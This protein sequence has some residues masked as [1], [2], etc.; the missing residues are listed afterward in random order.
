MSWA[1]ELLRYKE[2][3]LRIFYPS[4]CG[5]CRKELDLDESSLCRDCSTQFQEKLYSLRERTLPGP[6]LWL[7]GAWALFPYKPPVKDILCAIKMA[8]KRWLVHLFKNEMASWAS[9]L[10]AEH[11]YEG[12][13]P[14]PIALRKLLM[15]QFNQSELLA[16]DISKESGIPLFRSLLKKR[17]HVPAQSSLNRQ[18][19]RVNLRGIFKVTDPGRVRGHA[20]LLIDDI[21]TTG[22][23]AE[24]AAQALSEAGA[25]RIDLL[26]VAYTEPES[27]FS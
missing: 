22:A 4:F 1:L 14:V 24:A 23:T 20:W 25:S 18:E 6:F 11:A 3:F 10:H 27:A 7:N 17:R 13:L 5:S 21:L 19:R 8:G 12:V 9:A 15:R 2:A 16:R 26:T